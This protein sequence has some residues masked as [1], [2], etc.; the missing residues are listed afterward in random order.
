MPKELL[1]MIL[2]QIVPKLVKYHEFANEFGPM[3]ELAC[4]KTSPFDLMSCL[5]HSLPEM[6]KNKQTQKMVATAV[7]SL[8]DSDYWLNDMISGAQYDD[9]IANVFRFRAVAINFL[10]SC[11]Y[12]LVDKVFFPRFLA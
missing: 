11:I 1:A 8:L 12:E 9:L 4:M 10:E 7:K 5:Q 2:L 3:L 6:I